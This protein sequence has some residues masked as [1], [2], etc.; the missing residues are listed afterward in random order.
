MMASIEEINDLDD[1]RN[2]VI[3]TICK[4]YQ[5]QQGAFPMT[6]RILRRRDK[7]CGV[8]FCLHGPRAT[9]FSAIWETDRNQVLFYGSGGE[10]FQKT[11]LLHGPQLAAGSR[12]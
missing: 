10:R 2:Y 11:Q 1:L 12:N 5:L 8:H 3:H 6:E 9:L 7:P 4:Q